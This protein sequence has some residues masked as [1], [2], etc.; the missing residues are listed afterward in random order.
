MRGNAFYHAKM[1]KEAEA[2][3]K[4]ALKF[5]LQGRDRSNIYHM[6]AATY[7]NYLNKPEEAVEAFRQEASTGNIYAKCSAARGIATELIKSG[8][9]EEA[10]KE[11]EKV[12][13]SKMK[14]PMWI[15][16]A[17]AKYNEAMSIEK[18]PGRIKHECEAELKKL[19]EGK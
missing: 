11:L 7:S 16:E 17:K 10:L 2:D 8:K 4:E 14:N 3:Y 6:L 15:A 9:P 1:G 12:D 5:P 18:A 13:I 19:E